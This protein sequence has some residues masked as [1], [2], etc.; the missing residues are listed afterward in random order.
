MSRTAAEVEAE[1]ATLKGQGVHHMTKQMK[2]LRAE[3]KALGGPPSTGRSGRKREAPGI[4]TPQAE[5]TV[6]V[7]PAPAAA[8]PAA[9]ADFRY[10][11]PPALPAWGPPA[12]TVYDTD[13]WK[14]IEKAIAE[15]SVEARTGSHTGQFKDIYHQ[16]GMKVKMWRR[17]RQIVQ[18]VGEGGD[19]PAF[20]ELKVKA[21]DGMPLPLEAPAPAPVPDNG[22]IPDNTEGGMPINPNPTPEEVMAMMGGSP[23]PQTQDFAAAMKGEIMGIVGSRPEPVRVAP[24]PVEV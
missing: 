23:A 12:S 1:Y 17:V 18:D 3:L 19:W 20:G 7:A 15:I 9:P 21:S 13:E 10:T 11:F 14:F 22:A 2:A 6:E 4:P 5:V 24:K 8:I 16:L